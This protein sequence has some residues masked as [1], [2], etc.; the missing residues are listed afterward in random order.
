VDVSYLLQYGKL[1]PPRQIT[2]FSKGQ[3]KIIE[4]FHRLLGLKIHSKDQIPNKSQISMYNGP[5]LSG[6]KY[7]LDF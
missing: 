3:V 4:I 6:I 7:C 5:K 2:G 1:G